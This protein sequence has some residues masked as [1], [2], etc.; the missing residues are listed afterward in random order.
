[1]R[2][3][4]LARYEPALLPPCPTIRV[5]SYSNCQRSTRSISERIFKNLA[6]QRLRFH[7]CLFQRRLW[8]PW[9]VSKLSRE[10]TVFTYEVDQAGG[11]ICESDQSVIVACQEPGFTICWQPGVQHE[12]WEMPW[13][14]II[15]Q[16]KWVVV[17]WFHFIYPLCGKCASFPINTQKKSCRR[18]KMVICSHQTDYPWA[19]F[20]I[21]WS[22]SCGKR[23]V[24]HDAK[25]SYWDQMLQIE[26][27]DSLF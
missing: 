3:V 4:G 21:W 27:F 2:D 18:I 14:V 24:C 15:K 26:T 9:T 22:A 17:L 6:H 1:M 23:Y 10:C 11:G 7:C 16:S 25:C 8:T 12:L 19:L 20:L 5:L 13:S